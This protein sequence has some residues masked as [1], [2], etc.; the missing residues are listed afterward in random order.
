[1]VGIPELKRARNKYKLE[2]LPLHPSCLSSAAL[3]SV[4]NAVVY[5]LRHGS[6]RLPNVGMARYLNDINEI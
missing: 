4:A 3:K 2:A 1:M 5:I 6:G